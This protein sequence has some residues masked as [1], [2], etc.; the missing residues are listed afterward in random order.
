MLFT[1]TLRL[2]Q[3]DGKQKKK[4]TITMWKSDLIHS[5]R[6]HAGTQAARAAWSAA[7]L[8]A[9]PCCPFSLSLSRSAPTFFIL[10]FSLLVYTPFYFHLFIYFVVVVVIAAWQ[11]KKWH[12]T[13]LCVRGVCVCICV[14][15]V[16]TW[17]KKNSKI[18]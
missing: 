10:F 4:I 2:L 11:K 6:T 7:T 14:R 13:R 12:T 3:I 15:F 17:R 9:T 16:K 18:N 1:H 8:H 5:A